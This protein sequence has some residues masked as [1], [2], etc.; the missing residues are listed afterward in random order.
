V[1]RISANI[2]ADENGLLGTDEERALL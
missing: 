1:R 2:R